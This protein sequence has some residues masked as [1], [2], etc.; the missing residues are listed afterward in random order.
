MARVLGNYICPTAG[1]F[2][3]EIVEQC[4]VPSVDEL[5]AKK[6]PMWHDDA[7]L[8]QGLFSCRY[9][10]ARVYC[11]SVFHPGG[12]AKRSL[13]TEEL[14]RLYQLPLAMDKPLLEMAVRWKDGVPFENTPPPEMYASIFRQLWSEDMGGG[15]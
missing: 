12:F 14:L 4:S 8:P 9:P 15:E 2:N 6:L 5:P 1:G 13:T 3:L 7:L 11:K 10:Q